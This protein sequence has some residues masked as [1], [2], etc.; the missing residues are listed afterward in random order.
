MKVAPIRLL[1]TLIHKLI[2]TSKRYYYNIVFK[3]FVKLEA[4]YISL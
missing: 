4:L 2:T 1:G 3:D